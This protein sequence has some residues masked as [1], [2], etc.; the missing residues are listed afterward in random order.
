MDVKHGDFSM[1]EIVKTTFH[2]PLN[3]LCYDKRIIYDNLFHE[4]FAS[5]EQ[6]DDMGSLI[7]SG[8]FVS[9]TP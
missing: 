8:A 1:Q 7:V 4:G 5:F 3:T 6:V 2:V 9:G